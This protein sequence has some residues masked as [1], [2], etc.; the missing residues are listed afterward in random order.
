MVQDSEEEE[1]RARTLVLGKADAMEVKA[2]G[3]ECVN[4]R[5]L[6]VKED[7]LRRGLRSDKELRVKQSPRAGD[8]RAHRDNWEKG[9]EPEELSNSYCAKSALEL[10]GCAN[11]GGMGRRAEVGEGACAGEYWRTSVWRKSEPTTSLKREGR[12]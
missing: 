1:G 10:E 6:G 12:E 11:A 2:E 3:A 5:R 8:G 7:E 4:G 9:C